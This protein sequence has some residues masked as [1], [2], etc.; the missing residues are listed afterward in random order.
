MTIDRDQPFRAIDLAAALGT[1]P[2]FGVVF[3]GISAIRFFLPPKTPLQ[4]RY[5]R[6]KV[7]FQ[8]EFPILN[9]LQ[10]PSVAGLDFGEKPF[11]FNV[12]AG[13]AGFR[14]RIPGPRK[15]GRYFGLGRGW[16]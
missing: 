11:V 4:T 1:G 8:R 12:V 16:R 3:D 7:D 14:S 2:V 15:I 5:S 13:V 9:P 6:Y 10:E